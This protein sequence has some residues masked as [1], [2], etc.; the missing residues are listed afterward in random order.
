MLIEG[1]CAGSVEILSGRRAVFGYAAAY[2]DRADRTPLSVRFPLRED[3]YAGPDVAHWL[4]NLLPDDAEV[5]ARWCRRY[6]VRPDRPL[7]LLGTDVGAECAGAVQFSPPER[8]ADLLNTAGGLQ[9]ISEGELWEGLRVLR[10]DA[11]FRFACA[12]GDSG[13]SLA[14]MQPK[15][16][17]AWAGDRWAVPWGKRATTHI[18]KVDRP[19][20][21][22]EALVEHVTL[23]MA[24]HLGLAAAES[25]VLHG[26]EFDAI[27]LR[28]FDRREV[29]DGNGP[30]RIHQEDFCQALGLSPAGR[31]QHFGGATVGDCA[32]IVAA[33]GG[34]AATNSARLRD[35]VLFRWLVADT[36]GHGKNTGILLSGAARA[37][38]PLYDAASF[39]TDR[40]STEERELGFAMWGGEPWDV[41]TL[42]R[43]DTP[44]GLDALSVAVGFDASDVASR[45]VELAAALPAALEATVNGLALEDQDKLDRLGLVADLLD[46]AMRCEALAASP[47]QPSIVVPDRRGGR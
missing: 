10:R 8:T 43:T 20:F 24:R 7:G 21:R 26:E 40:G 36:D 30:E 6:G 41:W 38:T 31:Y 35:S 4:W 42:G 27:A 29:E 28:R 34:A 33:F 1:E 18:L 13:R 47:Q 25:R 16:A 3:P 19:T 44:G 12:Y 23:Q 9:E 45:V 15:D 2:L 11:S 39:L 37:L 22:H 46:R 14:G 32:E 5:L 17:L